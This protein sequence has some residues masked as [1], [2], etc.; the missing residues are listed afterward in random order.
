MELVL[1]LPLKVEVQKYPTLNDMCDEFRKV[2]DFGKKNGCCI[3]IPGMP[4]GYCQKI[5]GEMVLTG[6][7]CVECKAGWVHLVA[8]QKALGKIQ[9]GMVTWG[10]CEA[11]LKILEQMA[12]IEVPRMDE[13]FCESCEPARK[14]VRSF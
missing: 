1:M 9:T 4:D 10:H 3:F 14:K 5:N 8:V 11:A 13:K 2:E 7:P 12:A 6:V